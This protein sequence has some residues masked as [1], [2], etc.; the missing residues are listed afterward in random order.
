MNRIFTLL[1]MSFLLVGLQSFS[2]VLTSDFETWTSGK[3]T[4]WGGAKTNAAAT[5]EY[6]EYTTNAHGGLKAVQLLNTTTSHKRF[7]TTALTVSANTTYTISFWARGGG[8]I[9]TGL[10]DGRPGSSSGYADYNPYIVVN[11]TS[12]TQYTQSIMAATDTAIA[13]FILSFRSTNATNDHLQVDDVLI[14]TG[15][16]T[17]D[18]VTIYTIQY[19]TDASGNSPYAEQMVH[20]AGIVT[21]FNA[22]GYFIQSGSGPWNGIYVYDGSAVAVGDS[23]SLTGKVKEYYN[24]TELTSVTGFV[25]HASGLALPAPAFISIPAVKT[26]AYEGV[27]VTV[28]NV[29]C[30]KTNAGYGMWAVSV[31]TDTAKVDTFLYKYNPTLNAMYDITAIINY[32][33]SE[34]RL[35]PRSAADIQAASGINDINSDTRIRLFPNPAQ[36]ILTIDAD[37]KINQINIYNT[38]GQLVLSSENQSR[39]I[40]VSLLPAGIYILNVMFDDNTQ[41]SARFIR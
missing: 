27:L 30:A 1:V 24:F 40:D 19:T 23:V 35:S 21:G 15:T 9:R 22:A 10:F 33:F 18:T 14:T 31:G 29:K 2:Q 25:K 3:P 32:S 16:T 38:Q 26:E 8:E 41:S 36:D 4:G 17:I 7:T 39:S 6:K 5:T 11:S 37:G 20:T 13:E 28:A 34:Y 12:W